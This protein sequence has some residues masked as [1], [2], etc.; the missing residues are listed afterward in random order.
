VVL[1]SPFRSETALS[2]PFLALR[3]SI[4]PS[5]LGSQQH[6]TLFGFSLGSQQH[7]TLFL[8]FRWALSN[9]TPF[10]GF[11]FGSQ[12]IK[13]SNLY[14]PEHLIVNIRDPEASLHH[15]FLIFFFYFSFWLPGVH[16]PNLSVPP[17]TSVVN[18]GDPEASLHHS[19][20]PIFF[21]FSFWLPGVQVFQP[22]CPGAPHCEH[23]RPRGQPAPL[24][25]Y[26]FSLFLFG[27][28]AFK[29]SNLYAPEHLIVN[30]RDPEA[31]L[32]H[33]FLIFFLF[34]FL[35]PSVKSSNLYAPEHLIVNIR[36]P[37]ASLHHSFLIFFSIFFFWLPGVQVS[38]LYAPEHL[39][40]N[41][42]PEA[43]LHHSFLIFFFSLLA[44]RR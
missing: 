27:S 9:M 8:G 32:H 40:V 4:L 31:S 20:F 36:D 12:A 22:L 7:D 2:V 10:F 18:I 41:I 21:Y 16:F 24:F 34:S 39:I 38:D 15:S 25:P 3:N 29:F 11:S 19:S 33:F 23:P 37:E 28:Q 42:R 43:S 6:D 30:I 35:A 26:L 1:L 44:P 5:L 13:F 17:S 14:A